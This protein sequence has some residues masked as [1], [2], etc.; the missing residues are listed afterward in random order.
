MSINLYS[1]QMVALSNLDN[2]KILAGG[3]GSG[4]SIV[5]LTYY[6]TK[7]A[8]GSLRIN[9]SGENLPREKE[10]PLYI[11]TTAKKRD[12]KEW[13]IELARFALE[14]TDTIG[15]IVV[16]SWNN[17]HKYTDIKNSF[18]LFDE[19]RLV[20]NGT[21]VKS[22]YKIAAN[23]KWLMLSATPGDVWMDYVPVFIANGYYRNRT[24]FIRTHV[25]YNNFTKFPKIDRYVDTG[26][27]IKLR[28]HLLV[29][30]P[31]VRHTKRHV[32]H[33]NVDYDK[34][35]FEKVWKHRWNIYEDQPIK[36]VSELF[37]VIRKVVNSDSS[38][39]N[40][41]LRLLQEKHSRLIIFYNFTYELELLRGLI[42]SLSP[43]VEIA[44]WN[45][46]KHQPIPNS[47]SWLY[48]VQYTAGA[49]GWECIT[50]NAVVFYSLNYS[51]KVWEQ[52]M[53]RIDRYNT[54]F[55]DLYYYVFKS[56]SVIDTAIYKTIR[57]KKTFTEQG[58]M[59]KIE[60]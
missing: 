32:Q 46:Q 7:I 14:R 48:L 6:F 51:Y 5:A 29:E 60:G 33:V 18:V 45:G 57:S 36:D 20:G 12:G 23:N 35:Q 53:G 55:V 25:V 56:D 8:G 10:V 58:F 13:D 40:A 39:T 11:F 34:E 38:R 47:D 27:L 49:E 3:V 2:G 21:W 30:I 44:E 52:A 4:K 15:G 43:N 59:R 50:T 41:I 42:S 17:I 26:I 24:E 37:R 9:D 31:F 54:P 28:R 16:D 1:G 22:F 19:Q